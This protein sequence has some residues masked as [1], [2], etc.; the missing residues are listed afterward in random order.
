MFQ[1]ALDKNKLPWGDLENKVT[2]MVFS[3]LGYEIERK[4]NEE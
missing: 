2:K 1:E 3:H 4:E